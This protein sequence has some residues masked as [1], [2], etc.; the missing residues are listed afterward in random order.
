[1]KDGRFRLWILATAGGVL[2]ALALPRWH[3]LWALPLA[4]GALVAVLQQV[5]PKKA[6]FLGF[7]AGFCH[8]LVAVSWVT[9]VMTRYGHLSGV[10]A[11]VALA[12]MSAI[13]GAFWGLAFWAAARVGERWG[14]AVLALGL[15]AGE[16][17][18]GLPPFNFPWNPLVASL[19]PW[20]TLL[21]PVAVL[22]ATT[23]GLL[24]RLVLFAAA[25]GVLAKDRRGFRWAFW[26]FGLLLACGLAAPGFQASGKP[27]RA[28]AVQPNVP[29]EVRW[30]GENLQTI[31]SWVWGLSRQAVKEGAQWVVWPE[32]A[33][34]RLLERDQDYRASLVAFARDHGVWL[35]L[36]S[37]GFGQRESFYN[38]MYVVAPEGTIARYDKVH[39]VP[40]G[41]YVPLLGRIAFLRPL[42]REVGGFTPGREAHVLPGPEG[43]LGGAVC[44]EVAFPLHVAEQVR[45]G[46]GMLVTVTNDGWYG[47]SAAPYQHLVLAILRAAE[48]RRFLVRAAN[49]GISAIV[50]PYGRV[51][52]KLPLGQRGVIGESV[53]PGAGLTPAARFAPWLHLLPVSGFC[54]VILAQA[55]AS[56]ASRRRMSRA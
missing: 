11:F 46:A 6:F 42:V 1:M 17:A 9:E 47:D 29:L 16:M 36:N 2:T 22:G 48:N 32:S 10:L 24:L 14:W 45:K 21:A 55:W 20:P 7:W 56:F 13:L 8:W 18:Q 38:S 25:F 15:A 41:E 27:V 4:A 33:V 3:W 23:Y 39:L 43:F 26:G 52:Q 28:F 31:E 53:V 40:F 44:Y 34:P 5:P 54:L 37:I 30:E 12:A 50:D 51:L 49:T 19:V 35:T